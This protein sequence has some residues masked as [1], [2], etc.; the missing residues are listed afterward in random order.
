MIGV[1]HQECIEIFKKKNEAIEIRSYSHEF[2]KTISIYLQP[3]NL[4]AL[5]SALAS[6]EELE[7]FK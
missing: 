5:I 1:N 4:R 6:I 2:G 3:E 7:S